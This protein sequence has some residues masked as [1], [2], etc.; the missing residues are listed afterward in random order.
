MVHDMHGTQEC[1]DT[2][3]RR[4]RWS[5]LDSKACS[6]RVRVTIPVHPNVYN[7]N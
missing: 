7:Q 3:M 2:D 5:C 1:W 4:V 6:V